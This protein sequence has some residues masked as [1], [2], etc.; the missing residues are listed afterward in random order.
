[1][2][3]AVSQTLPQ[4]HRL[5]LELPREPVEVEADPERLATIVTNLVDNAVKYSPAGGEV[6]IKLGCADGTALVQVRDEG[7]G[8]GADDQAKLFTRFGR[9]VTPDSQDIAGTGLGLYLSRE[10]ARLHGG[11]ITVDSAPGRGSTFTLSLP[12][13]VGSSAPARAGRR[14]IA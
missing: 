4:T 5:E 3:A 1:V 8:I 6:R 2:A 10:L 13:R 12:V 7:I 14:E 9:V 11:D